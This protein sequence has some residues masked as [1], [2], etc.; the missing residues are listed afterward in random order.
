MVTLPISIEGAVRLTVL[1]EA[2]AVVT[3]PV[4]VI[5]VPAVAVILCTLPLPPMAPKLIVLVL[6]PDEVTVKTS[7][8]V[9][10]IAPVAIAPPAVIKV[11]S[12]A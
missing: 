6:P 7:V 11:T 3:L 2:L 1:P 5:L 12:L 8:E 4:K 9:P 10:V